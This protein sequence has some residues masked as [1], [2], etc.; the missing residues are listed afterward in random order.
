MLDEQAAKVLGF[1]IFVRI[2]GVDDP[3]L[4]AGAASGDVEAL[5]EK[6]LVAHGKRATLGGI[7]ERNENDV[8]LVA[9]E[10]RGVAA[11]QAVKF[12]AIRRDVGAQQIVD[13]ERLFV[14]DERN[15]AEA[16]RLARAIVL[17]LGLLY[18]GSD[19]GRSGQRLLAIH[20]AVAAGSR[21]V[22]GNGVR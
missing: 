15:Y 12:V 9:L 10:L 5:L 21:N 7:H 14:A 13:F 18:R 11:E 1:Q 16:E 20:F 17:I 8:A 2:Q 3:H 19:E 4:V 22:I 6:L